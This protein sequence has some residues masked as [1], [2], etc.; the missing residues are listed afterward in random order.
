[1]KSYI[2]EFVKG[3][4]DISN[5]LGEEKLGYICSIFHG[6]V[7]QP[8]MKPTWPFDESEFVL[9]VM[10]KAAT[11]MWTPTLR[12]F[13]CNFRGTCTIVME[14]LNDSWCLLIIQVQIQIFPLKSNIVFAQNELW[15][16]IN[17]HELALQNNLQSSASQLF[18]RIYRHPLW[19]STCRK[20]DFQSWIKRV[21][22]IKKHWFQIHEKHLENQK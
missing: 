13:E 20:H 19:E 14:L 15:I 17:L 4:A 10:K 11:N 9:K 7:L 2:Y 16:W 6:K 1:M 12:V 3:D 5:I 21:F 22:L 18:L 8:T